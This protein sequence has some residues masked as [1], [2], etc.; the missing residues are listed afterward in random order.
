MHSP[1]KEIFAKYTDPETFARIQDF[2][3]VTQMWECSRK[4]FASEVAIEDNG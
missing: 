4:E 3:T 2:E 1:S